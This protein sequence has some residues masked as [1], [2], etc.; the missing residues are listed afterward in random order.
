MEYNQALDGDMVMMPPQQE[1]FMYLSLSKVTTSMSITFCSL[2]GCYLYSLGYADI[3]KGLAESGRLDTCSWRGWMWAMSVMGP[4]GCGIRMLL[5]PAMWSLLGERRDVIG[6]CRHPAAILW[7]V[8]YFVPLAAMVYMMSFPGFREL[9]DPEATIR[10]WPT[11]CSVQRPY[12]GLFQTRSYALT[13]SL[14]MEGLIN[15][16]IV[17]KCRDP[18][19]RCVGFCVPV[20]IYNF[21]FLMAGPVSFLLRYM[22]APCDDLWIEQGYLFIAVVLL[23]VKLLLIA[24]PFGNQ[25]AIK[26]QNQIFGPFAY[27]STII[28]L[29]LDAAQVASLDTIMSYASEIK[30]GTP[31]NACGVD[32]K[33]F[34]LP[35]HVGEVYYCYAELAAYYFWIL[36]NWLW[37][38]NYMPIP[39]ELKF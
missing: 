31:W 30:A 4:A 5:A 18:D 24:A 34:W 27:W 15:L 6:A 20:V 35:R 28:F 38:S 8:C 25:A 26:S 7:M 14:I 22:G 13:G 17:I 10:D 36:G 33:E 37:L 12:H 16:W 32:Y 29:L 19:V 3:V 39:R 23:A 9:A 21:G 11:D 2:V 1:P